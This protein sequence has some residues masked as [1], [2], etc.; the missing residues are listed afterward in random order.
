VSAEPVLAMRGVR[1]L[2]DGT[3]VVDGVDWEVRPGHHW[4]VL[5]PNGAG[6]TSLVRLAGGWAHPSSGEVEVAGRRL[7]R[8]DVRALRPLVALASA[9]LGDLLR[10]DLEAVDAVATARSG[11]LEPWWH[12]ADEDGRRLAEQALARVGAANLAGRRLGTLSSGERQRVLIA[13]A[14]VVDPA[15][16]VLDEPAAGLDLAAREDLVAA[17]A[18]L[19]ADPGGPPVVLVTHHVDEIA[20][21]FT[22]VLMLRAGR[23][24]AAGPLGATLTEAN[25][26]ACF[27][28]PLRLEHR[29]GR[30]WAWGGPG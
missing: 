17:V 6:K 25:L 26:S 24:V 13:R 23:P 22:D 11:A 12:P 7:G 10:P 2:R 18:A 1:V 27:G 30:W 28:R 5:G 15:L 9:A 4:V 14:L 19:T 3:A 29:H 20:P 16:V 21:G 8:T